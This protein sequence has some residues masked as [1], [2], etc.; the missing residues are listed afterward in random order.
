[1]LVTGASAAE[2][3]RSHSAAVAAATT[4][5]HFQAH[6]ELLERYGARG[7]E[8]CLQDTHYHLSYLAEAI[9]AG[10]PALFADY[11]AWAKIMLESRGVGWRDLAQNLEFLASG[12][13]SHLAAEDAGVAVQYIEQGRI[14]LP[15]MPTTV[16][17]PE[18]SGTT[19]ELLGLY[20]DALL[21]GDRQQAS[22][23]ILAA[24][25]GGTP[26]RAIYLDVFQQAQ[27]HIGRLWQANRISVAQEHYCTAATQMIMSQLYPYIF[28]TERT[29]RRLV[30]TCVAGDLHEIGLRM[31]SDLFELEGWDT[32][33]LG[34]NVPHES[35]VSSV[36]QRR[37]DCLAI[38]ATMTFHLPAV[39]ALIGTLRARDDLRAVKV[40]VG[41]Y[42]F[43]LEPE[44]WRQV[45]ADGYAQDAAQVVDVAERLVAS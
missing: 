11:V 34:A 14:A 13:L 35:V 7:R 15:A 2:S 28:A 12:I 21:G 31:V 42:P 38:S 39:R 33:Y 26:I 16:S 5:R 27:H 18:L 9:S 29:D 3:L 19:G 4:E 36:E 30:A 25:E 17:A 41:G 43:N 45:G 22:R 40:L 37:A 6:P 1:V 44:L 23:L 24:A 10:S 32:F 8:K 20:I